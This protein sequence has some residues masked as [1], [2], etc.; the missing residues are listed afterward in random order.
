LLGIGQGITN[1]F[2]IDLDGSKSEDVNN[3]ISILRLTIRNSIM[4]SYYLSVLNGKKTARLKLLEAF[5][6]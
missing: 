6:I 1:W 3:E 5:P 2:E 4:S